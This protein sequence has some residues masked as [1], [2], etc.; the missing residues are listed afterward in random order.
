MREILSREYADAVLRA[1]DSTAI[2]AITDVRGRILDANETFCAI[3][4]YSRNE[5]VGN[6]HR[7][8]NSGKHS[9]HFFS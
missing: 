1:F 3:S 8:L 5:L 4:G 9:A 2:V 6:D 7:M